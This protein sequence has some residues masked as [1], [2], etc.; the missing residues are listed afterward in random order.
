MN[1]LQNQIIY[2]SANQLRK[3]GFSFN[4]EA[5][6]RVMEMLRVIQS[7]D[8]HVINFKIEE[9]PDG[10]WIAESTNID[11]IMTGSHDPREK[12]E[13]LK[14][15]VF[16]YFEIPPQLCKNHLLRSDNEPAR[17]EQRVHVGA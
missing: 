6:P 8:N 11:G 7:L 13:L 3:L 15:A 10:T 16:T 12:Q 5:D 17:I 9:H 14:D 4:E 2:F 1:R